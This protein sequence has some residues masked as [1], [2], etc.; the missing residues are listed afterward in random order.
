MDNP[1]LLIVAGPNGCGKTTLAKE[2]LAGSNFHYLSADDIAAQISP[3]DP[4]KASI[5]A[6]RKFASILEESLPEKQSWVIESTLAGLTVKRWLANAKNLGYKITIAFVFLDSV[7]LCLDRISTRV[8]NG[9]HDV[10][11]EDIR[12]RFPRSIHNFWYTYRTMADHW[13]LFYN[14]EESCRQ[15]AFGENAVHKVLDRDIF[16]KWQGLIA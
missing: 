10:P 7:E 11:E 5:I 3:G 15:I 8:A 6:A 16:N 9:G 4:Q 12:R 2:Y 13:S 1:E 14:T